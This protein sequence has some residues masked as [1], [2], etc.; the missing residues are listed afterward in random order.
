[1]IIG[2]IRDLRELTQVIGTRPL[3]FASIDV[4]IYSSTKAI[5]SLLGNS[6]T[7]ALLPTTSLHFDDVWDRFHY[8]KF[9]G[10]LLAIAEF[11]EEYESR[12]IDVDRSVEYWHNGRK[13]WHASMYALHTFDLQP[14]L[15]PIER[16][17][18]V[19]RA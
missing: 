14:Q 12:G 4:D 11:N 13:P 2:D 3:G 15:N 9:A 16:P 7:K 10:E 5:L 6:P 8:S 1:M 19:I 17:Q 18:K